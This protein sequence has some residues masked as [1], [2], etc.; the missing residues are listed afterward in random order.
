MVLQLPAPQ[1]CCQG[2]PVNTPPGLLGRLRLPAMAL[3]LGLY[4]LLRGLDAPVL[5]RLLAG[6]ALARRRPAGLPRLGA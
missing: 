3:P 4:V 1:W 6:V 2:V 5:K